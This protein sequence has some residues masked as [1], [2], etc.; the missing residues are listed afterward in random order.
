MDWI[1]HEEGISCSKEQGIVFS[2]TLRAMALTVKY[3]GSS[4][5]QE[6]LQ[7]ALMS[8]ELGRYVDLLSGFLYS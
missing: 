6:N 5:I 7:V 3:P 8:S 4:C 1:G 2:L